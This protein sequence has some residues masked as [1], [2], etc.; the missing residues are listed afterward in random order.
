MKNIEKEMKKIYLEEYDVY[1]NEY[2]TYAQIQQIVNSTLALMN[3]FDDNGKKHN[4]W[5]ERQENIDMLVLY[6]TTDLTEKELSVSHNILLHSGLIEAVRNSIKNYMWIEDAFKFQERWD[7]L[8][9]SAT[10][11]ISEMIKLNDIKK[12]REDVKNG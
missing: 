1:V 8:L 7:T 4:S 9:L 6:H 2:L 5:A 12:I 10:E 11:K 3:T